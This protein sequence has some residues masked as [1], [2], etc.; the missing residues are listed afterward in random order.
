M[1]SDKETKE[2]TLNTQRKERKHLGMKQ[3]PGEQN[4]TD[5][6]EG[7]KAQCTQDKGLT[8]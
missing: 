8:T 5:E 1:R 3:D 2:D 4:L 6:T 7:S